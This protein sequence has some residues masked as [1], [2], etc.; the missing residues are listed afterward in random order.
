MGSLAAIVSGLGGKL[1]SLIP[2]G[3]RRDESEPPQNSPRL[4][5]R[6]VGPIKAGCAGKH[7]LGR[8]AAAAN[9][10]VVLLQWVGQKVEDATLD[11]RMLELELLA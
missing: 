4:V 2:L 7:L 5:G 10:H 1:A 8:E 9:N 11:V 3:S 6:E